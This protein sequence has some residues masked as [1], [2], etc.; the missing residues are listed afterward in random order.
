MCSGVETEYE[1][2]IDAGNGVDQQR[3]EAAA[4]RGVGHHR[5]A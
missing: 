5:L 3:G 2:A 1:A 4:Q